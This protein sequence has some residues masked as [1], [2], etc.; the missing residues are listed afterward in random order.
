[1]SHGSIP[2]SRTREDLHFRKIEQELIDRIRRRAEESARLRHLSERAGVADLGILNEPS[3]LGHEPDTL[4]LLHLAPLV[5]VA[6]ADGSV[7]AAERQLILETARARGVVDGSP[8]ALKLEQWLAA[9]PS[10]SD[11]EQTMHVIT[12]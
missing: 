5:H 11:L 7:S 8:A 2:S 9:R 10:S 4:M 6:W 1:M 3:A 12:A